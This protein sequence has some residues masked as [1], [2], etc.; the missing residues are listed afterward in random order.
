M[1][2][3]FQPNPLDSDERIAAADPGPGGPEPAPGF[4]IGGE[5]PDDTEAGNATEDGSGDDEDG[6]DAETRA[7][8]RANPFRTPE[9]PTGEG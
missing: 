1:S 8:D 9:V 2:E 7:R 6:R 4:G 3:P 5:E